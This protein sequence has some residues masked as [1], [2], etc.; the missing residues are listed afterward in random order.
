V[1]KTLIFERPN[2]GVFGRQLQ[3]LRDAW[4]PIVAWTPI[5]VF[6]AF[7]ESS[8]STVY[9]PTALLRWLAC[10][11][12]GGMLA[13]NAHAQ[14]TPDYQALAL[15]WARNAAPAALPAGAQPLRVEVSVGNLDPRLK[16]APCANV[17]PY[18]PVGARLWGKNRIA[19]RCVD[20]MVRW[21]VSILVTVKATGLAWVVKN[22]V[23]AGVVVGAS[24]VIQAEVDWAEEPAPVLADAST[25]QGQVA[26]RALATGQ[27]LRQG[28]VKA[29][30]VFQAGAQVRVVAQGPGFQV[31]GDAQALSAG[32]IGQLARVRMDNGRIASG[33]VL[34]VHTVKIEL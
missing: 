27:T 30:Q 13:M 34:D 1:G 9:R 6:K 14:S 33:L 3:A 21:N 31:S 18:L 26:S 17:E 15:A 12:L 16:L 7:E 23:A 10:L 28:M 5:A 8:M 4:L 29:A 32:V 20:G 22:P 24:D 19:V 25:W 11:C 2:S